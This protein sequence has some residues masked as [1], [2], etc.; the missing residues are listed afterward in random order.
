MGSRGIAVDSASSFATARGFLA[1]G[2]FD[3]IILDLG[4]PDG[5]GIDWVRECASDRPPVLLL[6]ARHTVGERVVA[7]ADRA[8]RW[9]SVT[10]WMHWVHHS[11]W[12]PET[13]SNYSSVL[14]VWGRPFRK[15]PRGGGDPT[16]P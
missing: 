10:P 2:S 8:L 15:P 4:L 14:S 9:L 13:D 16:A 6:S 3:A 5:D 1:L 7:R 12:Q 11:R